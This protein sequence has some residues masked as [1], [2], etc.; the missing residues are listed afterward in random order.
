MPPPTFSVLWR[1]S[2]RCISLGLLPT[3]SDPDQ[4]NLQP[5]GSPSSLPG[6]WSALTMKEAG[7]T[8]QLSSLSPGL[9]AFAPCSQFWRGAAVYA[10]LFLGYT[11]CGGRIASFCWGKEVKIYT[12]PPTSLRCLTYLTGL[13]V[14]RPSGLTAQQS[15]RCFAIHLHFLP[16]TAQLLPF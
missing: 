7:T 6:S 2:V 15:H 9:N 11:D 16:L 14:L 4:Q 12:L 10:T 3:T 5:K 1:I 8:A 13:P